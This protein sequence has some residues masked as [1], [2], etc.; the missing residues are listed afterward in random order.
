MFIDDL[1]IELSRGHVG[2]SEQAADG[3]E[4]SAQ[5]QLKRCKRMARHVKGHLLIGDMS[6]FSPFVEVIR[7]RTFRHAFEYILIAEFP[8]GRPDDC[9]RRN[10]FEINVA[11]KVLVEQT[12][13]RLPTE[14]DGDAPFGF[15]D[16]FRQ[17]H[18]VLLN[19]EV[20]PFRLEHI[21]Y[22]QPRETAEE[23]RP[24]HLHVGAGRFYEAS[25]LSRCKE[26]ASRVP[27]RRN[28]RRRQLQNRV[29]DEESLPNRLVEHTSEDRELQVNGVHREA[30]AGVFQ[31]GGGA[32]IIDKLLA[33]VLVDLVDGHILVH[34]FSKM[35]LYGE[36]GSR[37]SLTELLP[38]LV[39]CGRISVDV[40][41]QSG[42][43]R[44]FLFLP[45]FILC[46]RD[47]E[48]ESLPDR[49]VEQ[50]FFHRILN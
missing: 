38:F 17:E 15:V 5:G 45:T 23:E 41:Q 28:D 20:A 43:S 3:V 39:S 9:C 26:R 40:A 25:Q 6:I 8:N 30:F 33:E 44:S 49:L 7:N 12:A 13:A 31:V 14:R 21:A 24:L 18:L 16:D 32:E 35:L 2:V 22:P 48:D 10:V 19:I 27:F 42:H 47:G 29:A 1:G 11:F 4:V 36:Y 46:E 34:E 37:P 50:Y